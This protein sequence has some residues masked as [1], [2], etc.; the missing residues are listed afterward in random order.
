VAAVTVV[1]LVAKKGRKLVI[2]DTSTIHEAHDS[3]LR[4]TVPKKIRDAL[5]LQVGDMLIWRIV[6]PEKAS[7]RVFKQEMSK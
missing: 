2:L 4:T 7:V 3:I 6:T 1:P 5:K